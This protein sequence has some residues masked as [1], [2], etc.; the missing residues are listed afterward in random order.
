MYEL[1]PDPGSAPDTIL[2]WVVLAPGFRRDFWT[3]DYPDPD[4]CYRAARLYCDAK[5]VVHAVEHP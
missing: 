3:S 2:S 4:T 1:R 5:N